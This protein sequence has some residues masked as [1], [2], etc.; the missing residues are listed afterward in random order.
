M[1]A[2]RVKGIE[3]PEALDRRWHLAQTAIEVDATE[4]EFSL[5][6]TFESFGRLAGGVPARRDR[7][8][9]SGPEN[10]MLHV[11]RMN[12]RPK[13]V[14]DLARLTNRDD[15]PNI[16][17]SLRKLIGAGLVVRSG[18]GRS[19]VTYSV[20]EKGREVTD[21]YAE[22]RRALLIAA[23][24]AVPGFETRLA[25]ARRTLELLSA[26]TIRPRGSRPPIAAPDRHNRPQLGI[27]VVHG[28]CL[29]AGCARPVRGGVC[30]DHSPEDPPHE[31]PSGARSDAWACRSARPGAVG[32]SEASPRPRRRERRPRRARRADAAPRTRDP[33]RQSRPALFRQVRTG[34]DG[35]PFVILKFR[36]MRCAGGD[37]GCSLTV[38]R[39]GAFLRPRGLDELPQLVNVL[40]GDMSLVGPRPHAS[41]E[42]DSLAD[43][44]PF[45]RERRRVRPG[46]SG[47][48]QVEGW[49]G[50]AIEPDAMSERLRHDLWYIEHGNLALDLRVIARSLALVVRSG[51]RG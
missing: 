4:L 1:A 13:S 48:A 7:P 36:T 24:E 5:M 49:R 23:I 28:L 19:G 46:I 29:N 33:A 3:H 8:P 26:S 47:W 18:S 12:D 31:G 45:Y 10:A 37:A 40:A 22:I 35:R 17:Y 11:I 25:E 32:G 50:P 39:L 38:T 42:D 43:R 21:R 27:A 16:Q 15:I 20:T 6:R 9:A 44:L 34:R 2:K 30:V 41:D 14:K 51:M